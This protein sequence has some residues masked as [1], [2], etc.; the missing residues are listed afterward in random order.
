MNVRFKNWGSHYSIKLHYQI[1]DPGDCTP[2][3]RFLMCLAYEV[4][5]AGPI[6]RETA[7]FDYKTGGEEVGVQGA[8]Y[9]RPDVLEGDDERSCIL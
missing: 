3:Y 7:P 5:I 9:M 4:C 8:G 2:Y 6:F 1:L